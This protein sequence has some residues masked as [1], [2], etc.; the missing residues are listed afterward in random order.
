[1]MISA[2]IRQDNFRIEL[3]SVRKQAVLPSSSSVFWIS[4]SVM[5]KKQASTVIG[6]RS[7]R[8]LRMM[9]AK[10]STQLFTKTAYQLPMIKIYNK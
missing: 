5:V 10:P 4:F 2:Y 9:I 7:R 3:V 6:K 8:E 1:M